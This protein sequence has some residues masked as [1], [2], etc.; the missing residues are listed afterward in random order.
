MDG[1]VRF[2]TDSIDVNAWQAMA[3][4]RGEE[5]VKDPSQNPLQGT[6]SH[7]ARNRLK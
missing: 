6:T 3:T 1:H 7:P 2:Y 4:I 5:V